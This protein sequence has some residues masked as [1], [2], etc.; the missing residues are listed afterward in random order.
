[1]YLAHLGRKGGLIVLKRLGFVDEAVFAFLLCVCVCFF[2]LIN[3]WSSV[4]ASVVLPQLCHLHCLF[5]RLVLF[6]GNKKRGGGE[7]T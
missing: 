2:F 5:V 7:P 4:V 1:M 3:C 6:C